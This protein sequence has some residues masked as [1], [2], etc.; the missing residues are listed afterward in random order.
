[1]A[2]QD[3]GRSQLCGSNDTQVRL[4]TLPSILESFS[5]ARLTFRKRSEPPQRDWGMIFEVRHGEN[6]RLHAEKTML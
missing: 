1:M 6:V 2:L 3:A 4:L 5:T